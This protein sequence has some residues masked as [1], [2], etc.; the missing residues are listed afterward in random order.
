M[1]GGDAT[2]PQ[3]VATIGM[4]ASASTWVFNVVRE[5]LIA[6]AGDKKVLTLY[7]D[8]LEQVPD[9]PAYFG[10]HLVIKSHHGSVELDSWLAAEAASVFLSVRDPRDAC[11]SMSQRFKAPLNTTAAWVANDCN[12]LVRLKD[13]G[14]PTLRYEDR[15]FEDAA[16]IEQIARALRL[17]PLPS[18]IDAIFARYRTDAV[19]L[20]ARGIADLPPERLQMVGAFKMDKVTQILGPHIGD[21]RDG[22][23]RDLPDQHQAELTRF[24]GPFLDQFGYPR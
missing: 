15:F 6:A 24:F 2:V 10:R 1:L 17:K 18:V 19:R 21:G 23:W 4:H 13:Q 5:L 3:V 22:K 9:E 8:K 20:L 12:R 16:V 7:A 11:I 14:Y